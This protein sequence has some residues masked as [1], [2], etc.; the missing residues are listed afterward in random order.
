MLRAGKLG[1]RRHGAYVTRATR[2]NMPVM[3]ISLHWLPAS[4]ANSVLERSH[5]LLLRGSC[6]GHVKNFLLQNCSVQVVHAVVE[7]DLRK[8]QPKADPISGQM[9]DVIEVYSAYRKI[10]QLFKC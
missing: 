6:A 4:F 7:R 10:A 5:A 3:T 1:W 8:W 9:I 2:R